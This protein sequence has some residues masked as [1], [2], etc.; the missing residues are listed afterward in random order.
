MIQQ[1]INT[2]GT[3]SSELEWNGRDEYGDKV[4][5]GTYLYKLSVTA[6]G[7]QRKEKIEKLV[8]F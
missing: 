2:D 8:I 5:R 4:G 7:G 1:T 6:P 3:R